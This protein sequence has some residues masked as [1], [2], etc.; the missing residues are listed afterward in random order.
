VSRRAWD[1]VPG[2]FALVNRRRRMPFY[3]RVAGLCGGEV[4]AHAVSGGMASAVAM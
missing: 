2:G 3:A 1:C 4:V